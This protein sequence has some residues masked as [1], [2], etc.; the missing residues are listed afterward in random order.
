MRLAMSACHKVEFG[1]LEVSRAMHSFEWVG[2]REGANT[3][4]D[5][6]MKASRYLLDINKVVEE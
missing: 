5:E 4:M 3:G 2:E 6:E 1:G